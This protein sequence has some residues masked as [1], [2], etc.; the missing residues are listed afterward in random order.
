MQRT[1]LAQ[2]VTPANCFLPSESM[3]LGLAGGQVIFGDFGAAPPASR[4]NAQHKLNSAP[5]YYFYE[6]PKA[7][8]RLVFCDKPRVAGG[9]ANIVALVE[10]FCAR[11]LT[12]K[13]VQKAPVAAVL[14]SYVHAHQS[15]PSLT[16]GLP[17]S[18]IAHVSD[19]PLEP[20]HMLV[21]LVLAD[22]ASIPQAMP[23]HVYVIDWVPNAKYDTADVRWKD[24]EDLQEHEI[25]ALRESQR[26]LVDRIGTHGTLLARA[27]RL[28]LA[29]GSSFRS[30]NSTSPEPLSDPS[31]VMLRRILLLAINMLR[32]CPCGSAACASASSAYQR[33]WISVLT[34]AS[35]MKSGC[36]TCCLYR[37][38]DSQIRKSLLGLMVSFFS[39]QFR[40]FL[41]N[42]TSYVHRPNIRTAAQAKEEVH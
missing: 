4:M 15:P 25:W 42:H 24:P 6:L 38:R 34:F 20:D 31:L 37:V 28:T 26:L 21:K 19:Q 27:D 5:P 7:G 9:Y 3:T 30:T 35:Q 18:E 40:G 2:R 22:T 16:S 29:K 11:K 36:R 12:K 33:V 14:I 41:P 13:K 23:A 10:R 17:S 32:S 1:V 39:S 8:F